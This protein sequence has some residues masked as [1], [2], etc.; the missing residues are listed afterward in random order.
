M[1]RKV[2]WL[3]LSRPSRF[4]SFPSLQP[5]TTLAGSC[6]PAG[7][8]L[9][10]RL[11]QPSAVHVGVGGRKGGTQPRLQAKPYARGP[12]KP[13]LKPSSPNTR[14]KPAAS[15]L[16]FLGLA[17]NSNC[18][19]KRLIQTQLLFTLSLHCGVGHFRIQ[20]ELCPC[21][22]PRALIESRIP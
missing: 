1:T 6:F 9:E 14:R 19:K 13:F 3:L 10:Q 21:L 16:G 2:A 5:R 12:R 7:G 4:L 15:H 18:F 20:R 11:I 8:S 17:F 22:W